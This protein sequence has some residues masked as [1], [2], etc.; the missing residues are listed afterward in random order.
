M[1]TRSLR[2][3]LGRYRS[4]ARNVPTSIERTRGP[5][6]R[7]VD[8][9]PPGE[10]KDSGNLMDVTTWC[11]Y[12]RT[13]VYLSTELAY[14]QLVSSLIVIL[15]H[16]TR[17]RRHLVDS[18]IHEVLDAMFDPTFYYRYVQQ[19]T[20]ATIDRNL[21]QYQDMRYLPL[22]ERCLGAIDGT[23]IKVTVPTIDQPPFRNRKGDITTNVLGCVD[24]AGRFTYVLAGWEG[25]A[26]D[27]KVYNRAVEE[28][29]VIPEGYWYL[30]DAGYPSRSNLVIPFR[31]VRYHLQEWSR[32]NLR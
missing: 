6:A 31:G 5:T 29:L 10:S 17:I 20:P 21:E 19:P 11:S 15:R 16:E 9:T 18:T 12:A 3:V 1:G 28:D 24:F 2:T 30:G 13:T 4:I 22:T 27:A 26:H 25:S 32:S 8:S 14:G 7:L 23:H